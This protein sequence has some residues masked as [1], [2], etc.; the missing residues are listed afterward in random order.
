MTRKEMIDW[1]ISN[2]YEISEES[3]PNITFLRKISPKTVVTIAVT[4][5]QFTVSVEY[6]GEGRQS[7]SWSVMLE[8]FELVMSDTKGLKLTLKNL[9]G[10]PLGN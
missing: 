7:V 8:D 4:D 9:I 6:I 1:E 10:F 5:E 2:G 3:L